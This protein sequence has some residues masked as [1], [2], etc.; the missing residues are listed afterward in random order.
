MF[1]TI[2]GGLNWASIDSIHA[3]N[4]SI[5]AISFPSI[6]EG[7]ISIYNQ[8][9]AK[10]TDGGFSWQ[11]L[12]TINGM[13]PS[14]IQ[15]T[16]TLKGIAGTG[17]NFMASTT[18]GGLTWNNLIN[19]SPSASFIKGYY[20]F[21]DLNY[22]WLSGW[23]GLIKQYN[24]T[25]TGNPPLEQKPNDYPLIYPNPVKDRLYFSYPEKILKVKLFTTLGQLLKTTNGS[26]LKSIDTRDI[27]PG[28]Y[29]LQ[30]STVKK[31]FFV[32]FIKNRS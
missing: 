22:G 18:D 14:F 15:F 20:F 6:N 4:K 8:G 1:K 10:T 30:L 17:D 16:D 31:E 26:D 11:M 24:S 32:K 23:N 27:M 29:F 7:Y 28:L 19:T 13:V 9:V 3:S 25:I 5:M 12:G 21:P 2:D